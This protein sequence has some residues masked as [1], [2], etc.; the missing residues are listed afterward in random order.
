MADHGNWPK[1]LEKRLKGHCLKAEGDRDKF[2]E[3]VLADEVLMKEKELD[4][5]KK[6][7]R[8]MGFFKEAKLSKRYVFSH[9][10][11]EEELKELDRMLA[12]DNIGWPE[13]EKKFPGFKISQFRNRAKI[14]RININKGKPDKKAAEA[15]L[16]KKK[17]VALER[18]IQELIYGGKLVELGADN[19]FNQVNQEFP[20]QLTRQFFNDKLQGIIWDAKTLE[21]LEEV[22]KRALPLSKFSG[23]HRHIPPEMVDSKAKELTGVST[24]AHPVA[25]IPGLG[26]I[27]GE[28]ELKSLEEAE[29]P[30]TSFSKPLV[31]RV[32]DADRDKG[33]LMIV[34]GPN[35]GLSHDRRIRTN[36]V[37]R[38]LADA[39]RRRDSV[40]LIVNPI[41]IDTVKAGGAA[42]VHRALVSGRNVNIKVLEPSYQKKAERILKNP[43]PGELIFETFAE[44]FENLLSGWWKITH[45]ADGSPEF[46]GE[47]KIVF[48]RKEE[49]LIAAAAYWEVRYWTIRRQN[50]LDV[51]IRMAK[52]ALA[53]VEKEE[54]QKE[55]EEFSQKLEW[56]LREKSRTI[57]SNINTEDIQKTYRRIHS[58]VVRRFEEAIPN[59]KV[60]GQGNV[61]V[62][63]GKEIVEIHIPR[64][65]KITDALLA[66]Y[67]NNYGP[68]V[69]RQQFANTVVI[70]H[71][72]ALNYRM[73][74]REVDK[75]G[76]RGSSQIFVAPI[77]VDGDF[78]RDALRDNV[79]RFHPIS[80]LVF[81]EQFH[82]GIL[83]LSWVNGTVSG[84]PIPISALG[85]YKKFA[86]KEDVVAKSPLIDYPDCPFIW[87]MFA[88][89]PHWGSRAKEF[90]WCEK[91]KSYLGI[92][93]AAIE[94]MRQAG[95]CR[96]SRLPIHMFVINDD[97]TQGNPFETH[98]QPDPHQMPYDLIERR[99]GDLKKI[100]LEGEPAEREEAVARLQTLG[101][102]QLLV[103]G[104][105]WPQHQLLEVFSR[106][107]QPNV[108]FFNAVL[109]RA[110]Q[111]GL[112][113]R[114]VSDFEQTSYDSRDIGA[115]NMGSGNHFGATVDL[116]LTEG[117][118]YAIWLIGLLNPLSGWRQKPNLL[119]RLIKAPLYGNEHIG[120]GTI[121][122][123]G[124]YEWG[125]ELRDSPTRL[126]SWGDTLL[127]AVRNDLRRANYSRIFDG[128]M[129]LK[130]YG[131][132]H[133][134]GAVSTDHTFYHM[135]A[136]GTHTDVYGER[137][138]P[139]NNTGV[140]FVGLPVNGPDSGPILV[141]TLRYDSIRDYFKKPYRFDWAAFLPNPA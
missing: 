27:S 111:A 78:L 22:V 26:R 80:Q 11:D 81:N 102:S 73:T 25:F 36:P 68:K 34:N 107:L 135:C 14:E 87:I 137:G 127:G 6:K 120:W 20:D 31:I 85:A 32:A 72:H 12:D 98:K 44:V 86:R 63:V 129:T 110:T 29:L 114:G 74:A 112:L 8:R 113:I 126:A 30:R 92:C 106:H 139:P 108:D 97:P 140:S 47:I 61:Y 21:S 23:F 57:V 49:E 45:R 115:I 38:A 53:R 55:T 134:F 67:A 7:A 4:V 123:P 2:K 42:K 89:D 133:F 138:F 54:N 83:R 48:G 9:Q 77:A 15:K 131:D 82:P 43:L 124:G 69:L 52:N 130:A 104:L 5:C 128:K 35:I 18:R 84:E 132:K 122:I 79:R 105:D 17:S 1:K 66:D 13:I 75:G 121:Q 64:Y 24:I 118:I 101:L 16:E 46:D 109:S 125:I 39:R 59:C 3:L 41:D 90:A 96:N 50:N 94:M 93:E 19:L 141:R 117:F 60:I 99:F 76:K 103:R 40:V 119:P 136:A 88:T 100:V 91:R 65:L 71:P 37:R 10:L 51:E 62:K 70:C 58:F 56:L 116:T 33:N 95:L 28:D